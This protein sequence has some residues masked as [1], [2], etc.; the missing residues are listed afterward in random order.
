MCAV[1]GGGGDDDDDF[2][3]D[4]D[5][6]DDDD[7]SW[8]VRRA[9]AKVLTAV[10]VS[11]PQMLHKLHET[12]AEPLAVCFREREET[13]RLEIIACMTE[14]IKMTGLGARTKCVPPCGACDG[15]ASGQ[16]VVCMW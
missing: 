4:A 11:R 12:V 9:A 14:L 7:T 16:C 5:Y 13:V 2:G 8:K 15:V 1:T 10:I 6:G 3:G